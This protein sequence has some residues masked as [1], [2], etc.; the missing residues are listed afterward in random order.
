[1]DIRSVDLN[2]L[3]V[4]DALLRHRSVTLSA[5]ELSM[6]Q[7]ALSAALGRLRLLL[8]DQLFVRTGH[9]LLPT[10]RADALAEP[11]AELLRQ[12]REQVLPGGTFDPRTARRNFHVLLSDVGAYVL[13]PRL[14]RAVRQRAPGVSLTLRPLAG[15][16]IAEDLAAG[17][18][19]LAIGAY[20]GLPDTLY[21]RR[22]FERYFVCLVQRNHPLAKGKRLSL[23]AFADVPQLV[24]RM[25]SGIQERIDEELHR[26]GLQRR[27][28][29]ELPSYLMVPPLLEAGDF[30]A[31]LP[32]QL[33]DAFARSGRYTALDLPFDV[34]PSIIH[35]HWHRRFQED[36]ASAWLRAVVAEELADK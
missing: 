12:V 27:D 3:P 18:I 2:L 36:A 1:M 32:G 31:V 25:T 6:S 23:R 7:S 14:V 21:Q 35:M 29:L 10:P 11:V 16:A 22:L 5:H 34:P 15:A 4:L 20:P 26:H 33:S 17:K 28:V 13:L 30:L 9:G 8:G 19:D 24:V